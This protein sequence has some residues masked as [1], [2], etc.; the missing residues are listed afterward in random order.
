M[1]NIIREL[2]VSLSQAVTCERVVDGQNSA[3][4]PDSR[5]PAKVESIGSK[6]KTNAG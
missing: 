2:S 6:G 3:V 4:V 5:K 1:K